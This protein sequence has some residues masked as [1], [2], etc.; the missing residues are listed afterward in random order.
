MYQGQAEHIF[1]AAKIKIIGL[2]Y[3]IQLK[4]NLIS[5]GFQKIKKLKEYKMEM[6]LGFVTEA[7]I[8]NNLWIIIIK[9]DKNGGF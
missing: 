1:S 4:D 5:R 6:D 2:E 7:D 8:F 9:L 3:N